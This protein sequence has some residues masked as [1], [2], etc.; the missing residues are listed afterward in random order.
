M[1]RTYRL[2]NRRDFASVFKYGKST[3]NRYFVLYVLNKRE[4]GSVRIGI[5]VSKKVAKRAVDRNRVKRLVKEVVRQWIGQLPDGVDLT[6]IA[7]KAAVG[8]N[9][10]QTEQQLVH[11]FKKARLDVRDSDAPKR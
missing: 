6:I 8:L 7:R 10:R 5:S 9:Y 2:R 3:A 4:E 1:K 11:V